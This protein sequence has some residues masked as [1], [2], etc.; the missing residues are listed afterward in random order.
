MTNIRG[1]IISY[2]PSML[3]GLIRGVYGHMLF[4]HRTDF[5]GAEDPQVS[6]PVTYNAIFSSR[7]HQAV[8]IVK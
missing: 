2:D 1:T 8:N 6:T 4:F 7:G 3:C 5:A